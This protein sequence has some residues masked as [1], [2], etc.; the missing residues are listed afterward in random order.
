MS[1]EAQIKTPRTSERRT[2]SE[3]CRTWAK[4]R[5]YGVE[6]QGRPLSFRLATVALAQ[7]QCQIILFE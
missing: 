1:T 7:L 2:R 6:A 5:A 3:V 4:R